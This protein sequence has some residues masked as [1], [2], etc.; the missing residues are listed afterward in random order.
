MTHINDSHTELV[1]VQDVYKYYTISNKKVLKAVDGISL[2]IQSG[3]V[4][5]VVGESGCGKSTLGKLLSRIEPITSGEVWF[6]GTC[7][8][9]SSDTAHKAKRKKDPLSTT[10]KKAFC[11]AVQVVF[12]DPYSALNPRD[13]VGTTLRR[14][15]QAHNLYQGQEDKRI[16]T[17]LDMVGLPQ[18]SI[19]RYPHE[20]SGGQR[21]RICIARALAVEPQFLICDEPISALD[22]S[23]QAQI[24]NLMVSLKEQFGLTMLFISHDLSVVK[25]IC[26]RVVVM[27]LGVI[28]EIADSEE[29][30]ANP[31]H[32]Y[33]RA[34]LS[35]VP[36]ADPKQERQRQRIILKGDIPAPVN[37]PA[38]CPFVSRC[39]FAQDL[40]RTQRPTLTELAPGHFVACHYLDRINEAMQ[41]TTYRTTQSN[42]ANTVQPDQQ[43]QGAL[44]C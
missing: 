16:S 33:T 12:Q 19:D 7:I 15:L 36:Q 28:V 35:A 11:K 22:V 38:G 31:Q 40:C 17:L 37:P 30:Y 2:S 34:L 4:L 18:D 24:V 41:H 5:G 43:K 42:S 27:Y 13:T 6:N 44:L 20:F 29:L 1:R 23:V 10:E 25:Y 26:D 3:E 32:Y 39:P 9:A 8:S 14:A 21:Q